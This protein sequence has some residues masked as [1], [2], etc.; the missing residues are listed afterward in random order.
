MKNAVLLDVM[1]CGPR[2]NRRF[3]ESYRFHT[4]HS[5]KNL[6][7]RNVIA[8]RTVL[9]LLV[10]A[11]VVACSPILVALMMKAIPFSEK[12]VLTSVTRRKCV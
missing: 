8:L 12:P 10:T 6:R 4:H 2:K 7:A 5:D 3:G 11:N 9:R 1:T